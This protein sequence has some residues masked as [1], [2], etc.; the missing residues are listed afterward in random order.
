MN[1]PTH[2][3]L[4]SGIGGFSLAAESAGFRTVAFAE[5]DTEAGIVLAHHWPHVP[6]LGN[7][8]QVDSIVSRVNELLMGHGKHK[9]TT[10]DH[11]EAAKL[12]ASGLSV[13]DVAELYGISR[14][15]MWDALRHRVEMR[16]QRKKGADNHFHRG[17]RTWEK[18]AHQAVERALKKGILT[19]LTCE[20]CGDQNS[21]AHHDD[22]NKPLEV[23][24]LCKKHHYEWHEQNKPI[25][26]REAGT[27][28]R[29]DTRIDLITAGVP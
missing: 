22:Y 24:W 9:L 6:N 17:G 8:K 3:D 1:E 19:K 12:Y 14:Q 2:L 21:Q 4:F 26:R 5:L 15:A 11:D 23:R 28:R 29:S 7:I 25:P 20:Q 13:G 16:P 10:A 18:R 27:E